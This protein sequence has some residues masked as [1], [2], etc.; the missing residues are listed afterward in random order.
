MST[1]QLRDSVPPPPV[2]TRRRYPWPEMEVGQS[3]V[4]TAQEGEDVEKIAAS[5]QSA[6]YSWCRRHTDGRHTVR[7]Q[8]NENEGTV[9][10]W[11]VENP[12]YRPATP[13]LPDD[14]P[15]REILAEAGLTSYDDI[16][17][18]IDNDFDFTSLTGIGKA[19]ASRIHEASND[20]RGTESDRRGTE[21]DRR[22]E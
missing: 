3:F 20:R 21:P 9:E 10:V 22:Q 19:L 8:T 13:D 6:G 2:E 17:D 4:L 16:Q 5:V 14:F 18:A 15:A 1:I 7:V 11:M 12:N